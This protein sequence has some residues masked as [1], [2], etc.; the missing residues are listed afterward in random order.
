MLMGVPEVALTAVASLTLPMTL[1]VETCTVG[2]RKH[3]IR[4]INL[5]PNHCH[6]QHVPSMPA[7]WNSSRPQTAR[8]ALLCPE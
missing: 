6:V 4:N 2:T 7:Y 8:M 1:G 3:K 5:L